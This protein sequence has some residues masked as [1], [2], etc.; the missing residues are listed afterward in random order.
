MPKTEYTRPS[1]GLLNPFLGGTIL[2]ICRTFNSSIYL[3][4]QIVFRIQRSHASAYVTQQA[5]PLPLGELGSLVA[6][7]M[8]LRFSSSVLSLPTANTCFISISSY[9]YHIISRV[10]IYPCTDDRRDFSADIV[11]LPELGVYD[12][13]STWGG[14]ISGTQLS[15]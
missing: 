6:I 12:V 2:P 15:A 10:R 3:A 4:H 7:E 14:V 11:Y 9:L 1:C 5:H 13:H 8:L